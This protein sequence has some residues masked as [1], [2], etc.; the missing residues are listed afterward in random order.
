MSGDKTPSEIMMMENSNVLRT[1]QTDVAISF[2]SGATPASVTLASEVESQSFSTVFATSRRVASVFEMA[3]RSSLE[4]ESS[5]SDITFEVNLEI[6]AAAAMRGEV[7]IECRVCAK[8]ELGCTKVSVTD[9]GSQL[10]SLTD[11]CTCCSADRVTDADTDDKKVP[12]LNM[13]EIVAVK[14]R[15]N[16]GSGRAFSL[17]WEMSGKD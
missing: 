17:V 7:V 3:S 4:G 15:A 11:M 1:V 5:N 10:L 2:E 9:K 16:E 12:F 6:E 14:I 8:A 13:A